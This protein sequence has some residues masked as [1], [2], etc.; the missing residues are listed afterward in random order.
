MSTSGRRMNLTGFRRN[1]LKLSTMLI[2]SGAAPAW[3]WMIAL[4]ITLWSGVVGWLV[5][6]MG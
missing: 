6:L 3:F 5:G 1:T 2:S 4:S